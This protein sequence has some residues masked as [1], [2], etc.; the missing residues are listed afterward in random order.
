MK[1]QCI[2]GITAEVDCEV[3]MAFSSYK[4]ISSVLQ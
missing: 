1:L 2:D 3:K 4:D